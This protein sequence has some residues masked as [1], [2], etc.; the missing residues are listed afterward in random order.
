MTT[1]FELLKM[2]G[3]PHALLDSWNKNSKPKAIWD[4]E[5]VFMINSNGKAKLNDEII[6]GD[7]FQLFQK[8]LERW[9]TTSDD[10]A[11]VG[12]MSY[13]LKNLLYPHLNFKPNKNNEPLLWFAKPKI[14]LPYEIKKHKKE[15]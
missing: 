5:E 10:L 8:T 12:Y 11:A 3:E 6:F 2:H 13:D 4:F 14:I 7:P 15:I 9:K 1:L